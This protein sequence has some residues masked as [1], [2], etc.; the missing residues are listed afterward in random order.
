[1]TKQV[2]FW[3]PAVNAKSEERDTLP[4]SEEEK[5]TLRN[6]SYFYFKFQR[7]IIFVHQILRI[8]KV[9]FEN[10]LKLTNIT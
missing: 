2:L 5:E 9:F 10:K 7:K 6:L 3:K 4:Q 1:M 8:F